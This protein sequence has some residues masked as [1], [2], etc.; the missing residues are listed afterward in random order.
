MIVESSQLLSPKA[1]IRVIT[2]LSLQL[3]STLMEV[4][5]LTLL[6][7]LTAKGLQY[8]QNEVVDFPSFSVIPTISKELNFEMQFLILSIFVFLVFLGRTLFS[9]V[10]NQRMLT[11]LA[12]EA[13]VV[14]KEVI[15]RLLGAKPSY[16]LSKKSQEVLYGVTGGVDA[17]ILSFLGST[18]FFIS[19]LI[20]ILFMLTSLLLLHP[21]A[22]CISLGIFGASFV[23][24]HRITSDKTKNL[25]EDLSRLSIGYNQRLLEAILI[26]REL[27]L[28][29][30][31]E[32]FAGEVQKSRDIYVTTRAKLMFMPIK[33]KYLYEI[34]LIFGAASVA[35]VEFM[36]FDS[37]QA[38]TALVVFLAAASRIVPAIVRAQGSLLNMKQG[39]GSA[40]VTINQI[41]ELRQHAQV[42]VENDA[43]SISKS[44]FSPSVTF[45]NVSFSYPGS[46]KKQLN[47]ISFEIHP[48]QFVAIVGESGAG[49][50]T[51]ADVLLGIY[52]PNSGKVLV[53]SQAAKVTV[54][55]WPGKIAYVPQ[56]IAIIDGDIVSNVA[57]NDFSPSSVAK[58]HQVIEKANLLA[59]VLSMQNGFQEVVGERGTRLS[60]GQRQRLAIAR[61]LYTDPE[62]II[63]DEA[64]SALDP[65]SEKT[66]T[67][68][69]YQ[70]EKGV[71]LIVIAH[72]LSTVQHADLVILL[73]NGKIA[74]KGSFE[75]VRRIEPDFD[76]QAKLANL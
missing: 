3:I 14:S 34:V 75:E 51:L 39:E 18:V 58:V 15:F 68:K 65:L 48:G 11:F 69:I 5:A 44:A 70:K 71:T 26:L 72:R 37:E 41:S 60:G 57:L 16:L 9:V 47:D 29:G 24:L 63:F 49:K 32:E 33:L 4:L 46:S 40:L 19:D 2:L 23:V 8:V 36:L 7:Y 66:V 6:G 76:R 31:L 10:I 54:D 74:A 1:R 12:K 27:R 73:K 43:I 52:E 42:N 55:K 21:V 64:T 20:F 28:R 17:L 38:I 13:S 59:D 45:E 67:E 56:D 30:K 35:I 62:L 53:S 61:A 25:S 22:G 50:S